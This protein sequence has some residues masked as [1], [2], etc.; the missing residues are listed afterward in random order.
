MFRNVY[1]VFDML[2]VCKR[3]CEFSNKWTNDNILEQEAPDPKT[4]YQILRLTTR[5]ASRVGNVSYPK[6]LASFS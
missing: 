3:N 1:S 2:I 4:R 6:N 5:S